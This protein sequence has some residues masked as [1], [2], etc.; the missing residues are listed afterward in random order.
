MK[1]L[2]ATFTLRW[3]IFVLSSK[4]Q[5]HLPCKIVRL[6]SIGLLSHKYEIHSPQICWPQHP[7]L[8]LI[9]VRVIGLTGNHLLQTNLR[10]RLYIPLD[11]LCEAVDQHVFCQRQAVKNPFG[12]LFGKYSK[13]HLPVYRFSSH[14]KSGNVRA[15]NAKVSSWPMFAPFFPIIWAMGA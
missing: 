1:R 2:L 8:S 15:E 10:M 3:P 11:L 13:Y 12:H 5:S 7:P 14:R 4:N 9:L 6:S